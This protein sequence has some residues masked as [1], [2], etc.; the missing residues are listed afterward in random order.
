M[1]KSLLEKKEQLYGEDEKD[2]EEF[3]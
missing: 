2:E 3:T 1:R